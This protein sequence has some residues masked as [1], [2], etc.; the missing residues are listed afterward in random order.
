MSYKSLDSSVP[1]PN[2]LADTSA[3]VPNMTEHFGTSLM[4]RS[5]LCPKC[6]YTTSVLTVDSNLIVRDLILR[7]LH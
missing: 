6:L 2:C 7:N 5:V 4:V 3:L 1:E